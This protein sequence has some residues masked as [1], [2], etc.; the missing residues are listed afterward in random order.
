M[1]S[2]HVVAAAVA[3]LLVSACGGGSDDAPLKSTFI[4][5]AVSG[6]AY[7]TATQTGTTAADGGFNYRPGESVTFSVGG[8]RLPSVVVPGAIAVANLLRSLIS[9]AN[10]GSVPGNIFIYLLS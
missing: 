7:G 3:A 5:A 6:A 8:V 10:L 4:D 1:F 9:S 2:K